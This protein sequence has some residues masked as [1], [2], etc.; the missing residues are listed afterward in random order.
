MKKMEQ[1]QSY[2]HQEVHLICGDEGMTLVESNQ[3]LVRSHENLYNMI[4]S[5][6]NKNI[7]DHSFN[8]DLLSL[9]MERN[10]SCPA[11]SH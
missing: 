10:D 7:H 8:I 4:L 11:V 6:S 9:T 1:K 2:Q 5:T 3:T